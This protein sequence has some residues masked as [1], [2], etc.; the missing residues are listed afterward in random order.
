MKEEVNFNTAEKE[1]LEKSIPSN[2]VIGPF[3][4]NTENLRQT[5][6]KKRKEFAGAILD[7]LATKVRNQSEAVS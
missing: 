5:L 2:I 4:V 3:W 6:A 1:R 7:H